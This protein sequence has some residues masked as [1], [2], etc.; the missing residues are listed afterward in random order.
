MGAIWDPADYRGQV[1]VA[2]SATQLAGVG[3]TPSRAKRILA[4]W[5]ELLSS[6]QLP[7]EKLA[8]TSRV[9]Q[10][11]LDAVAGLPKLRELRVKWG[12]YADLAPLRS[13]SN[14]RVLTLR[15][16]T[17]LTS[18]EPLA[19]LKELETLELSEV[20]RLSDPSPLRDLRGLRALTFGNAS[21]SS[22]RVVTVTSVDFLVALEKLESLRLPGTRLVEPDLSVFLQ[23][24]RLTH[25]W[26]PLR[27]AYRDQVF[28]LAETSTVFAAVK[29]NYLVS[30]E[31][32]GKGGQ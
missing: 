28:A 17:K 3:V 7:I 27:R 12:P 8:L 9:P 26:I 5:I 19:G 25:L 22:D 21:L 2:I 31:R 11:L 20:F 14:L 23:L 15:G 18:V 6:G 30:E 13:L 29:E 10:D 16:A 4:D 24:P 32:I 1:E